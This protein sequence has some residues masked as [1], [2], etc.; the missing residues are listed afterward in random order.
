MGGSESSEKK[1][2]GQQAAA[3]GQVVRL[4]VYSPSGGAHAIYHSGVEVLDAE[5][6]FGGG[7]TSFSGVTA[8]RPRIPP[9]GSGWT[10]YQAVEIGPLR[11][12]RDEALRVVTE[13]RGR[14]PGNSYDLVSRNCNHFSEEMCQKL[15]GR[16]IPSWVNRLAGIGDAVRGAV[17]AAPAPGGRTAEG[18]AGGPAAAGLIARTANKDG[19][20]AAEVDWAGVGVLNAR[21]ADPAGSL[22]TGGPISSADGSELLILVPFIAPTKLQCLHLQAPAGLLQAPKRIRLFANQ[23]DLDM[24]DAAGGAAATQEVEEVSWTPSS[25][26]SVMTT[27]E[28][29]FLKFQRLAFLAIYLA[30]AED[31]EE[32]LTVQGL[33]LQGRT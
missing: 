21:E 5:Y 25:G 27:V 18:G 8:Q 24:D 16:S 19:D 33:R 29:N 17:G 15:C 20:L 12:N 7:D 2:E 1:P 9:P 6:V 31:S 13:L 28:V 11:C 32:P 23:R 10:F 4:N 30:G 26:A 22:R 3:A 14:F